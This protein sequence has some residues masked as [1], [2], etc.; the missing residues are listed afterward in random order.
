MRNH[1]IAWAFFKGYDTIVVYI[2]N[3]VRSL[4]HIFISFLLLDAAFLDY[5]NPSGTLEN[6]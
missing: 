6:L 4:I 3:E 5:S 2:C 1:V